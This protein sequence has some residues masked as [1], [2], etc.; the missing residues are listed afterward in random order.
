MNKSKIRITLIFMV[1]LS[2][3]AIFP[4]VVK[5]TE[6]TYTATS[7]INGVTVNWSY[8]LN[9]SN[10]IEELICTNISDLTGNIVIPSSID[11][12]NVVSLGFKAFYGSTAITEV[13]LPNTLKNVG[14]YAFAGC[15]SL[16]KITILDNVTYIGINTFEDHN[17][18]LTIY[19]YEGSTAATYAIEN[20]IKYVYLT[21]PS[22]DEDNKN[23]T[24]EEKPSDST[25]KPVTDK[26]D[27]TTATGKLPQTG[28]SMGISLA[29]VVLL[30][31]CVFTYFKYNKLRGI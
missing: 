13:T 11:G 23:T 25:Q 9:E 21:R 14:G 16:K 17:E 10:E 8:E 3:L 1:L 30:A 15:T 18:D 24:P 20:K 4:S 5:A 7:T 22:T 28:L 27:T 29:I 26:E 31:G 6:T 12:K 19:C 2:I